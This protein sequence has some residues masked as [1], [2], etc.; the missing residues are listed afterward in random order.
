MTWNGLKWLNSFLPSVVASATDDVEIIIADNASTDGT[1]QWVKSNYPEV[2]VLSFDQNYGY[3]GG[4]NKASEQ[5]NGDVL[6]F[7]NNDVEVGSDWLTPLL[8]AFQSQPKLGA[9]Q[10]KIRD[11][12]DKARFEYAGAAGGMLDKYGYPYCLG[13]IFDTCEI[14]SG[15]YDELSKSIFWASG[16]AIAVRKSLF[17]ELGGFDEDFQ[18]HMEEID[19]C[20][21]IKRMNYNI[22]SVPQSVVYHVGGG[23][24][25]SSSALKLAYN[26]RNNLT[27][28]YKHLPMGN[29]VIIFMARLVLDAAAAFREL[30]KGKFRHFWAIASAHDFFILNI[31][32]AH[33]KRKDLLNRNLPF[34]TEDLSPFL[35]PWHYF[36][37]KRSTVKQLPAKTNKV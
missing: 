25:D 4:N 19:L 2:V 6:I 12:K 20:W 15:Q 27:M 28:L 9:A 34:H 24:L 10:P 29:F 31:R 13:R 32:S 22:S 14:D 8:S 23:S 7:L 3:C 21:K 26:M 30:A 5:A 17:L 37:L 33:R 11:Y 1:A 35:L 16:A 36:V 18:F